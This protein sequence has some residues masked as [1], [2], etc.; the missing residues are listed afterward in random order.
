M[1][2]KREKL[3]RIMNELV[4]FCEN[5]NM[6]KLN[7][8]FK[9]G[10]S[11]GEVTISGFCENPPL[12]RLENLESIL[13]APRQEE[14]EEYYWALV[15]EDRGHQELEMIGVLVDG[16]SISYV[17]QILTICIFRKE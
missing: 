6:C 13:N 12:K 11:H 16:G 2:H 17:D 8:T 3:M 15:G 10:K 5:L 7:I 4:I 14:L 1:K 9:L